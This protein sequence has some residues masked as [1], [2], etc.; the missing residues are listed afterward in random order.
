MYNTNC[1]VIVLTVLLAGCA[2]ELIPY[3]P[4]SKISVK[5]ASTTLVDLSNKRHYSS[6]QI[7]EDYFSIT[8]EY[9]LSKDSVQ[10]YF[11]SIEKIAIYKQGGEGVGVY[12]HSSDKSGY[13]YRTSVLKDAERY[14]D[15]LES[16]I[17]EY[18]L[19]HKELAKPLEPS[20]RTSTEKLQELES[21]KKSGLI[22]DSEYRAKKKQILD[23]L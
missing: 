3:H 20:V 4:T 19:K 2:A 15:A 12:V 23:S 14:V 7:T 9:P 5:D 17:Y 1:L 18:K 10:I 21:L 13:V 6:I 22:T 11:N 16:L 8:D